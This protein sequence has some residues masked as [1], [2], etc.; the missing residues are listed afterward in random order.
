MSLTDRSFETLVL[1]EIESEILEVRLNRPDRL[2][3][4]NG[5]LIAELKE[6]VEALDNSRHFRVAILTG[7][8]RGFCAGADMLEPAEPGAIPGSEGMGELGFV[9]RYQEY[10]GRLTLAIYEC[11]KPV[12]AAINGVALGGGCALA[13]ACDIRV[14]SASARIGAGVLKTGLSNCDVGISYLLPRIV[15]AGIAAE[16]MLTNRFVEAEEALQIGL[17]SR[18]VDAANLD[19]TALE[20]ACAIREGSEYG[21]WMTKKTLRTALDATSLRHAMEMENRTQVLGYF[22]GAMTAMR[23]AFAKGEQVEWPRL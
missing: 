19:G 6:V 20:I 2:N 23:E 9:Y 1:R 15:G 18:V 13:L 3:A 14:A 8:G 7:A 11:D 4:I 16:L 17:A 5:T 22:T 21:I 12:I 10:I